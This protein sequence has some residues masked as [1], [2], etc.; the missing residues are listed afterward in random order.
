MIV[1]VLVIVLVIVHVIVIVI[2]I[3]IAIVHVIVHVI[4]IV[5]AHVIAPH[6]HSQHAQHLPTLVLPGYAQ[7]P[8]AFPA[9]TH[10][11]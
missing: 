5:I 11:A 2:V 10:A 6:H 7:Y 8:P 1:L 4:V 9:A 3:A